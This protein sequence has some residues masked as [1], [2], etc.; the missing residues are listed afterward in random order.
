MSARTMLILICGLVLAASKLPN[1]REI[2]AAASDGVS[3]ASLSSE[4][5]E[6][7]PAADYCPPQSEPMTVCT[8]DGCFPVASSPEAS[9]VTVR[10]PATVKQTLTVHRQPVFRS[11][12]RFMQRGPARRFCGRACVACSAL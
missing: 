9:V 12:E 10:T 3:F 4:L 7:A 8:K 1:N 6:V 5:N 2:P 11:N